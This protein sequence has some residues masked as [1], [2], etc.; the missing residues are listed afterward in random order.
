MC[1]LYAV[2]KGQQA[3]R[4]F[5]R[6]M[7][8][9]TGS[10]PPMPAVFPDYGAPI[11][12]NVDGGE[13]ELTLMRWGFPPPPKVGTQPV[14]NVR[15]VK[16]PY[17][18]G[19]LKPEWRA[20]V[21]ATPFSEYADAKPQKTPVW[22]ALD[23][24]RPLFALAGIW[25]PWTGVRKKAEGEM[26]HRLFSFLTCEANG[27]VAPIHPKA[28]PV[29]LTTPDEIVTW[30]TAPAEVALQLQRPLPDDALQIAAWGERKDEAGDLAA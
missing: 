27:V 2:T 7:H 6:A 5:T 14:S 30:L 10:L 1:N 12:R 9:T 22:F 3:I 20:M 11:V 24:S 16:S 17:W 4:E 25:R 26:E 18:R 19:W 21:P 8:D 28:M 13:R 15:N 23:E 29:I